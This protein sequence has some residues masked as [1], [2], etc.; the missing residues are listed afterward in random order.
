[1]RSP[2]EPVPISQHPEQSGEQSPAGL[3]PNPEH[4]RRAQQSRFQTQ[5]TN[6]V[7]SANTW[8]DQESRTQ[9]NRFQTQNTNEE[10]SRTA[11][12][13]PTPGMIRRAEPSRTGSKPRTPLMFHPPTPGA[14]RRA[15]PS[16]TGS[17][18]KLQPPAPM[19]QRSQPWQLCSK[20]A[21]VHFA[22]LGPNAHRAQIQDEGG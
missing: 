2:A 10:P 11:S 21:V 3:V 4:Q 15:E 17:K 14:I 20:G 13:P 19:A 22:V 9:Q 18:P 8:S 1:M 6:D 5:N 7:P 12:H 16:R